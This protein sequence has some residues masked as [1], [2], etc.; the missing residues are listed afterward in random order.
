MEVINNYALALFCCAKFA[1]FHAKKYFCEFLCIICA[2]SGTTFALY[3]TLFRIPTSQATSFA[4]IC[5]KSRIPKNSKRKKTILRK[6]QL[7]AKKL[8]PYPKII[9]LFLWIYTKI[10]RN[11]SGFFS[12]P[13]LIKAINNLKEKMN[14]NKIETEWRE[15]KN[16]QSKTF[17]QYK[18]EMKRRT[19]VSPKKHE[20]LLSDFHFQENVS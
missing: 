3:S 1:L 17:N 11:I 14:Q 19:S 13:R 18:L 4:H 10:F 9:T 7:F 2:W 6:K 5:A 16:Q 15:N 12:F 20:E 8:N